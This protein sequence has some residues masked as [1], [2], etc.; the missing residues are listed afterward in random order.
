MVPRDGRSPPTDSDGY[1]FAIRDLFP[2]VPR[3]NDG[4]TLMFRYANVRV[5]D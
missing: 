1:Y 4:Q 2:H 5:A 3:E